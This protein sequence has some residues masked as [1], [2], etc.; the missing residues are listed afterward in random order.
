MKRSTWW[1]GLSMS[2]G[3]SSAQAASQEIRALFQPDP[4]HPN[5]NEFVNQTPDSG[6]CA[7]YP[8]Q[9]AD[10]KM[11][12]IQIPVRFNS[13]RALRAGDAIA[14]K[15]PSN[16]RRL[17]VTN[18]DTQETETVEVR[19]IGIGSD[20]TLSDT[21]A[22]LVGVTDTL[23]GHQKLWTTSSWVYAPSPCQYSGVGA[24]TP[25]TYRFFWK[26]PVEAPC[27]KNAAYAI[28][29]ITFNTL[30]FTYELRTPNPLG[31]SSGLYTGS[32]AYSLGSGGDFDLG[33][34]MSPDDGSVSLDFVLDVQ[35]TLKV[36]LPPG[37]NKVTLEPAGGWQNWLDN[38]RK[39]TRFYR[40]QPYYLSASSRFK[41]TMQCDSLGGSECRMGSP[42]G[43]STRVE[44]R[45]T[46]PPGIVGPGGVD[47]WSG[48]L[49]TNLW[50]GPFQP[51]HYVDR[52]PGNLRFEIPRMYIDD[53][54]K[55]GVNDTLTGHIT[56][57][58][59][60]EV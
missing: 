25:R 54:L 3:V 2:L 8:D 45:L 56:I 17:T 20:F 52:K 10:H 11:F 31:M 32:L 18:R 13:N 34:L 40:D 48:T 27:A 15:A 58:W 55:P 51:T 46:V 26:T 35:H 16:W 19:I 60:S 39:P 22:N 30:D 59:D 38:G 50:I 21:A 6:Y 57:I 43:R 42:T 44:T 24:Y 5:K 12:S 9:C 4:A 41:V 47:G 23:E 14:P 1:L 36:D 28:P 29:A 37:G 53:L 49:G 33:P 7:T